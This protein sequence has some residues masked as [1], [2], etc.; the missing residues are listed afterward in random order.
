MS[1]SNAFEKTSLE[2]H[3][4]IDER[5]HSEMESKLER[6]QKEVEELQDLLEETKRGITSEHEARQK[7]MITI[8]GTIIGV[9]LSALI[10]TIMQLIK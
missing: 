1:A 7:Q 2:A 9:L 3:V 4:E 5:R 10:G 6:L 8:A